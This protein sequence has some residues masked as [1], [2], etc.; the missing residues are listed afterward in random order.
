MSKMTKEEVIT[1]LESQLS[2]K[3]GSQVTIEQKGSWY[4]VDGGKSVRFSELEAMLAE[5]ATT[6]AKAATKAPAAKA[7]TKV[8]VKKVA[9]PATNG[10]KTP[11]E[12]WREKLNSKDQLPRGF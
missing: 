7:P 5:S 11:K 8:S 3:K 6:D 12:L 2:T 9:K 10:G 1:A 4:K